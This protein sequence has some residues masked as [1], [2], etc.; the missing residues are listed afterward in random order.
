MFNVSVNYVS[1]LQKFSALS[2]DDYDL[3]R[4][5]LHLNSEVLLV[6]TYLADCAVL[7]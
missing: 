7:S 5:H 4:H 6:M 2:G 1:I 3:V